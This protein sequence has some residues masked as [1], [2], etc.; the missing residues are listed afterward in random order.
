MNE[1]NGHKVQHLTFTASRAVGNPADGQAVPA[2]KQVVTFQLLTDVQ[3][4]LLHEEGR[5]ASQHAA[6][7]Y[8]QATNVTPLP[9]EAEVRR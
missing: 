3:Q 1:H 2:P 9:H 8:L 7:A 4:Q 6:H 5:S